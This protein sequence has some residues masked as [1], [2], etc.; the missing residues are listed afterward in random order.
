MARGEGDRALE[1]GVRV[2]DLPEPSKDRAQVGPGVGMVGAH[3]HGSSV[4]LGGFL[5]PPEAAQQ[6]R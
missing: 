1:G 6:Q 2:L 3:G 5:V 4:G